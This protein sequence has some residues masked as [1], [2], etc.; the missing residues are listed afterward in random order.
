MDQP[1]RQAKF[2]S[3]DVVTILF[4]ASP[5]GRLNR[6]CLQVHLILRHKKPNG[7]IEEK[8]L[9]APPAVNLD[10]L[11]H[12]YTAIIDTDNRYSHCSNSLFSAA[13]QLFHGKLLNIVL[14][15][16]TAIKFSLME[17]RRKVEAFLRTSPHLSTHLKRLMT[18][19]TPSQ[20]TG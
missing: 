7:D 4:Q 12:V 11:T 3:L 6:G 14:V 5:A 19:R 13:L 18:P 9:D 8:H 17:R 20:R 10:K 15:L 1:T 16:C 2:S